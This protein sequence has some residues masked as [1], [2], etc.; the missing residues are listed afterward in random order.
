MPKKQ[1]QPRRLVPEVETFKFVRHFYKY[2]KFGK[3][4]AYNAIPVGEHMDHARLKISKLEAALQLS[5]KHAEA[6]AIEKMKQELQSL[7]ESAPSYVSMQ[8]VCIFFKD[9]LSFSNNMLDIKVFASAMLQYLRPGLQSA[10]AGEDKGLFLDPREDK[11]KVIK[12]LKGFKGTSAFK[13][14]DELVIYE[15]HWLKFCDVERGLWKVLFNPK[16]RNND[17]YYL[18]SHS[19]GVPC[20]ACEG[21]ALDFRPVF[22]M[23]RS[24]TRT[25]AIRRTSVLM[26]RRCW[27]WCA[28]RKSCT[29]RTWT[30]CW[31][32]QRCTGCVASWRGAMARTS[33]HLRA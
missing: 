9:L 29:P 12:T 20:F 18:V 8:T 6:D 11:E 26:R 5:A 16:V 19:R 3:A 22:C 15:G 28:S 21:F 1:L 30:T 32:K 2:D 10:L 13:E 14:G 33:R 17:I 23:H 7:V 31:T 27:C 25:C 24:S 4:I